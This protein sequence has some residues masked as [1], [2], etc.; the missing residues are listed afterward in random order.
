[1]FKVEGLD[2]LQRDL[3][4]AQRAFAAIDG[5]LGIVSFDAECP[6]SIESAIVSM[7]QMIEERL[8]PYTNNSIV[9]PMIGE[10]KER[11]RTAIIDKAAEA[12]LAGASDDG[13]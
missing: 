10:M 13:E 2:K 11:Y 1:M 9:G 3:A 12:R 6:D 4:E 5:E 7:E 8:G